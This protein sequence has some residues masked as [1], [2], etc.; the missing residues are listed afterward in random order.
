MDNYIDNKDYKI[1]EKTSDMFRVKIFID[2]RM[3]YFDGHFENFKLL[4]AIAQVKIA[5]DICKSIFSRNFSVSKLLKLKFVN[6]I[7]PNTIITLECYCLNNTLS[8]KM[9]DEDK[10][11]SDG[12]IYL[13]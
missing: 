10:K 5:L 12:K 7:F 4:P 3:P 8:F 9:Y 2:E 1:E 13:K 6:M 11:Y